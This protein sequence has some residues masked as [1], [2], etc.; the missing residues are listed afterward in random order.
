M[1]GGNPKAFFFLCGHFGP[2]IGENAVGLGNPKAF[3][4]LCGDKGPPSGENAVGFKS[5]GNL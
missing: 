3:F 2:P 4:F 5:F 1:P